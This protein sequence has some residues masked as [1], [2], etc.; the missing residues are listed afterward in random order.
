MNK[1]TLLILGAVAVAIAYYVYKQKQSAKSEPEPAP[2][3]EPIKG[4]EKAKPASET[5]ASKVDR[6][7][8]L[9]LGSKGPEVI[10]LQ[11]FLSPFFFNKIKADGNFGKMTEGYLVSYKT[12]KK[13][14][15]TPTQTSISELNAD[16]Q[17]SIFGI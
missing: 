11:R 3:P 13:F 15:T 1:T 6:Y 12:N 10:V 4:T 5:K 7:K 8:L 14:T 9:K 17:G 16:G 2:A